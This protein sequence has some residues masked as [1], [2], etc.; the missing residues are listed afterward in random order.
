MLN[1]FHSDNIILYFYV[2]EMSMSLSAIF[3]EKPCIHVYLSFA[4]CSLA[5]S[6]S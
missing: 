5:N 6:I 2:K 3:K 1:Q 4:K